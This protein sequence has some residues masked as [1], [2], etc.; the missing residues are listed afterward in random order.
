M[1]RR[2]LLFHVDSKVSACVDAEHAEM[3]F[4]RPEEQMALVYTVPVQCIPACGVSITALSSLW[5]YLHPFAQWTPVFWFL[6]CICIPVYIYYDCI[7]VYSVLY[8]YTAH[9]LHSCMHTVYLHSVGMYTVSLWCT[10]Q[11]LHPHCTVYT[12]QCIPCILVYTVVAQTMYA[13]RT[14]IHRS[15]CM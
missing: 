12:C 13:Y 6:A 2:G 11:Y 5:R 7:C 15:H 3:H 14:S 1:L 9:S 4:C 8:L 10:I